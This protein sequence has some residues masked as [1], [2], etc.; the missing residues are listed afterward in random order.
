MNRA[1][2]DP[3]DRERL[4]A[5]VLA[6]AETIEQLSQRVAELWLRGNGGGM[7][8]GAPAHALARDFLVAATRLMMRPDQL[9]QAHAQ[10][11]QGYLDLWHRSTRRLMDA[12]PTARSTAAVRRVLDA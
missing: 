6:Q 9:V 4:I 3:L 7:A 2:L 1:E 11:W 12:R 5:L 10:L 8:P